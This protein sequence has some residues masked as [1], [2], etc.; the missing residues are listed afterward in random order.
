VFYTI[1]EHLAIRIKTPRYD[2]AGLVLALDSWSGAPTGRQATSNGIEPQAPA[3]GDWSQGAD[4]RRH[5]GK[6]GTDDRV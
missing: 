1:E 3:H 4:E 2:A 5:A 6:Q